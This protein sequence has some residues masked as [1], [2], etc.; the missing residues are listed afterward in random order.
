MDTSADTDANGKTETKQALVRAPAHWCVTDALVSERLLMHSISERWQVSSGTLVSAGTDTDAGT[1]ANTPLCLRRYW[2]AIAPRLT[3]THSRVILILTPT[4]T[5]IL[6]PTQALT[7]ADTARGSES[8]GSQ[9]RVPL[10]EQLL[11]LLII[12]VVSADFYHH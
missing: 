7:V 5:Q 10:V 9:R 3:P 6:T 2:P 4:P 11:H 1:E 12:N 8:V